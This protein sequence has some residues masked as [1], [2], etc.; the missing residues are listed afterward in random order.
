MYIFY[1][2]IHL[3]INGHLILYVSYVYTQSR[4]PHSYHSLLLSF[5][6]KRLV[7][8][9]LVS[10][11]CLLLLFCWLYR[12]IH[13]PLFSLSICLILLL[14]S[15]VFCNRVNLLFPNLLERVFILMILESI[16]IVIECILV[17]INTGF[18]ADIFAITVVTVT[19]SNLMN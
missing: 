15:I 19:R 14:E 12:L 16:L 10:L 18:Q 9:C 4:Y 17:I 13:A 5:A 11:K 7:K 6:F 8:L 2:L 1:T 3:Y